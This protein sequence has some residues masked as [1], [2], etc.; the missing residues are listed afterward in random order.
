MIVSTIRKYIN[1][2]N[3]TG[4]FVIVDLCVQTD[5]TNIVITLHVV[6]N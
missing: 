5:G 4:I 6:E 2:L 3:W 1:L